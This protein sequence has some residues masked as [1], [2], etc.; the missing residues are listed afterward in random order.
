MDLAQSRDS[1]HERGSCAGRQPFH[2]RQR[3]LK[4]FPH[5]VPRQISRCKHKFHNMVFG[6]RFLLQQVVPDSFVRCQQSPLFPA[7]FGQ[8]HFVRRSAR[9]M[10]QVAFMLDV[11]S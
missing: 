1:R 4:R 11:E 9:K 5:L 2:F 8:P 7:N 6:Q 10:T 3:S